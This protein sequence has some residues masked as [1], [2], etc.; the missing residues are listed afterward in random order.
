MA[1]KL[2]PLGDRVVV[3]VARVLKNTLRESDLVVRHGGD[4]FIAAWFQT[5]CEDAFPLAKRLQHRIDDL[6]LEVSPGE[7]V[8]VGISIA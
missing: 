1:L 7:F 5:S 6:D 3:E 4:K 8:R 2:K